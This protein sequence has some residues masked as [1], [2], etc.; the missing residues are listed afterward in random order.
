VGPLAVERTVIPHDEYLTHAKVVTASATGAAADSVGRAVAYDF[1]V[2]ATGRTCARPPRLPDRLDMF[3]EDR[4]RINLARSVMIVGGRPIGVELAAEIVMS[5]AYPDK[6]SVTLVHGG[7]RLLKAMG[8]RASVKALEWPR[9]KGVTV[10][11]D[12]TVDPAAPPEFTTSR[13]RDGEGGLLL[14]VHGQASGVAAGHL[15]RGARERGGP[16][17]GGRPPARGRAQGR[18]HHR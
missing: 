12:Q 15:P 14:R 16:A 5:Y 4:S 10:L 2:I 1:L 8:A 7:D 6:K 3:H 18:A 13:R 11:L 9:Y 17:R